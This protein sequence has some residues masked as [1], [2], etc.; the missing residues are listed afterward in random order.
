MK[1]HAFLLALFVAT[2]PALA[3]DDDHTAQRP[4]TIDYALVLPG[5]LPHL[6]RIASN[7]VERLGL[8]AGQRQQLAGMMAQAPGEVMKRLI[9][10]EQMETAIAREVLFEGRNADELKER[11]DAL[12]RL[13]RTV[14]DAQIRN[15]VRMRELLGAHRF[16]ALLELAGVA[17]PL[18]QKP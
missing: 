18:P 5:N 13:K 9:Q 3:S 14:T 11:L 6:L 17:G 12:T 15:I 2:L 4:Q 16:G 1:T 10:A 7:N 8:D